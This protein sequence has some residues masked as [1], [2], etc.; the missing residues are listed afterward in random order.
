MTVSTHSPS[1]PIPLAYGLLSAGPAVMLTDDGY[2]LLDLNFLVSGGREGCLAFV[3][4]GDSMK[5]DIHQGNLVFIDTNRE[6]RNGDF[7]AVSINNETC[8][9][10]FE[11]EQQRLYLVP[12]NGEYPTREVKANDSFHVLGV[13]T[14][15]F[16]FD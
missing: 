12:A 6:P 13:V 16:A 11:R 2:A 8:I 7:V 14:S 15:H 5:P 3:V 10:R 9:K 4:T 1:K